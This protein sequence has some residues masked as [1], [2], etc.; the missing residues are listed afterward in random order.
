MATN[1]PSGRQQRLIWIEGLITQWG[2]NQAL[3]GL[4]SAQVIDLATDIANAR[5]A[6]STVE[7]IRTNSKSKTNTYYTQADNVHKKASEMLKVIKGAAAVSATPEVVYDA[8]GITPNDPPSPAPAPEQPTINTAT[9]GGNG[10]ITLDFIGNGPSGTVWQVFRMLP[11][12]STFAFI[13]NA[14]PHIKS[15]TDTTVPPGTSTVTYQMRGTRG[16][17]MGPSSFDFT[18][19]IGV[20]GTEGTGTSEAA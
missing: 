9:L 2:D 18:A 15:F 19:K 12:Q 4:T 7:T 3:L 11:T 8:A 14:N 20:Q 13:G 10:S 16:N 1:I 6:F 5:Q 17:Q